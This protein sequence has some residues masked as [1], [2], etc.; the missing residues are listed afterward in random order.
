[1]GGTIALESEP[2]K[3][4]E[5]I[6][7]LCFTLSGQK[8][9]NQTAMPQLEGLRALVADDDTNTCLSVSTML[10]KIGMRRSGPS[11]ARKRSSARS[12]PWSRAMLSACIS[13]IGSSRI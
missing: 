8:A 5:F 2:G 11:P 7:N 12:T 4:S 9:E 3:G 1:M 13:S 6:V 10:S